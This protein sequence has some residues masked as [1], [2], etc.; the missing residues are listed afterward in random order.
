MQSAAVLVSFS[1]TA[2]AFAASSSLRSLSAF[3]AA[4][5]S[6]SAC[7]FSSS[8]AARC[9]SCS[10]LTAPHVSSHPAIAMEPKVSAV[11]C[12]ERGCP[13]RREDRPTYYVFPISRA[14]IACDRS[15]A[16]FRSVR[17]ILDHVCYSAAGHE[18]AAA[19]V[20][21][22]AVSELHLLALAA[23]CDGAAL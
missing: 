20:F 17:S 23:E 14:A 6:R 19:W 7:C 21:R 9:A 4:T 11:W 18:S 8:S 2:L 10:K 16:A 15:R 22:S 12:V 1:W 5:R 3:S 13:R